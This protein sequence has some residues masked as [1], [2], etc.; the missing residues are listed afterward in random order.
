M[1]L[2]ALQYTHFV[3]QVGSFYVIDVTEHEQANLINFLCTVASTA[4]SSKSSHF[5]I[6]LH[7]TNTMAFYLR[8]SMDVIK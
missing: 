6:R 2:L 1:V 3:L 5:F 8:Y 4:E 7:L